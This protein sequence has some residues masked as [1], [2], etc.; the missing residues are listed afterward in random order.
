MSCAHLA[1]TKLRVQWATAE[2]SCMKAV[3]A[4]VCAMDVCLCRDLY[5]THIVLRTAFFWKRPSGM[6]VSWF[7]SIELR[8][9]CDQ[10]HVLAGNAVFNFMR[11]NND[12]TISIEHSTKQ[13]SQIIFHSTRAADI[14]KPLNA[15]IR[16]PWSDIH[17]CMYKAKRQQ[18]R[19]SKNR[20]F[21]PCIYPCKCKPKAQN[22]GLEKLDTHIR[23]VLVRLSKT[24]GEEVGRDCI[25]LAPK[26]LGWA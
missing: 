18:H 9:K 6:V 13:I 21:H 1:Y 17:A 10:S 4:C 19:K 16:N 23:V 20:I 5:P 15:H 24:P 7:L 11:R 22:C 14:V 12:W 8:T 26:Y 3:G 25:K 2:H